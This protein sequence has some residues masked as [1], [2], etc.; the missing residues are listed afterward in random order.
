MVP[1]TWCPRAGP[2]AREGEGGCPLSGLG[3]GQSTL[4]PPAP[5]RAGLISLLHRPRVQSS[6]WKAHTRDPSQWVVGLVRLTPFFSITHASTPIMAQEE[7]RR[8]SGPRNLG[9]RAEFWKQNPKSPA[10]LHLPAQNPPTKPATLLPTLTRHQGAR[11]PKVSTP[12]P[13]LA[14][15]PAPGTRN[16]LRVLD[17]GQV[18]QGPM[19][20]GETKDREG[21]MSAERRPS[22]NYGGFTRGIASG[23]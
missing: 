7:G 14:L 15:S 4:H 10:T 19:G 8:E 11:G 18:E 9:L 3:S 23:P 17:A 16:L 22:L 13:G 21:C 1:S 5:L 20:K 12:R 2:W 6:E